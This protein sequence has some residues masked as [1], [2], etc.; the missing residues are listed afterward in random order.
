MLHLI[1]GQ[2]LQGVTMST[3]RCLE[4]CDGNAYGY[5][6]EVAPYASSHM[7]EGS[8]P[9]RTLPPIPVNAKSAYDAE[10][11][12]AAECA[13]VSTF[14]RIVDMTVEREGNVRPFGQVA[15]SQTDATACYI[16]RVAV[17]TGR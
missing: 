3:K 5:P 1:A 6:H 15:F 14:G 4:D 11:I 13:K 17:E 16:V 7:P 8:G 2:D 9:T 10:R 12:T